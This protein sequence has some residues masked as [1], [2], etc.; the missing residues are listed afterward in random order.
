V[1]AAQ[2]LVIRDWTLG[3]IADHWQRYFDGLRARAAGARP[4]AAG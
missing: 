2:A 4:P 1:A 3:R